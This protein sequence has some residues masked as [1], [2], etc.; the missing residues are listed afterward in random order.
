MVETA[1]IGE[2]MGAS[3]INGESEVRRALETACESR[4]LMILVTPYMRFET[5]FLALEA[6]AIQVRITMSAEEATYGLRSP[7]LHFRFPHSIRFLDGHT[8]LLGFGMLDG[9]RTLRLAI[10]KTLQDDELRRAYRVERVGRVAVTFSTPKFELKSGLLVDISTMGARL[11]SVQEPLEPLVKTGDSISVSIPLAE[12]ILINNRALIRWIQGKVMGV[13][14]QPTLD[15]SVLTPLSRWVF[16]RR[17][18]DKERV[19]AYFVETAPQAGRTPGMVLVSSSQEMEGNL[20]ELL[21]E[22][23]P[24]KRVGATM[25]ALKEAVATGPD[26]VFFHVPDAGLDG[27]KRLKMLVET[28]GGKIP[29]VLLGTQ[30]ENSVLFDLGNEY[31]ASAVYDLSAKPGPFFLRLVQGILRRHQGEGPAKEGLK[32]G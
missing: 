19:G 12:G 9:R 20:R 22:L 27:R 23:P 18:E 26:L 14:F 1:N 11:H 24:L 4:E 6:D 5:N 31:K 15:S 17:E 13:E 16:L 10:P 8:K 2:G 30:V 7:D 21:A 32:E 29:F 25:Q 3:V 28:L